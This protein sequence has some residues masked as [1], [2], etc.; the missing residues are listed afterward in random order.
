MNRL[1]IDNMQY[2]IYPVLTSAI[3]SLLA[4]FVSYVKFVTPKID[5]KLLKVRPDLQLRKEQLST[6]LL[7]HN[8]IKHTEPDFW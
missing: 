4:R 1:A 5:Q 3:S 8:F 6:L 7:K 2:A